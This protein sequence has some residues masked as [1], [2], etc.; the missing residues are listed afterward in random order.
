MVTSWQ[1][2]KVGEKHKFGHVHVCDKVKR[3][4]KLKNAL[5]QSYKHFHQEKQKNGH[6]NFLFQHALLSVFIVKVDE[7]CLQSHSWTHTYRLSHII[8]CFD[9]ICLCVHLFLKMM[10]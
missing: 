9:K 1:D 2:L 10:A 6:K 3:D 8:F 4:D 5:A 7:T